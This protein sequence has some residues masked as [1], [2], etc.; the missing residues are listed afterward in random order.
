MD[1]QSTISFNSRK[2]SDHEVPHFTPCQIV[3]SSQDN[4]LLRSR[5][6][7]LI[8]QG[9]KDDLQQDVGEIILPAQ[10]DPEEILINEFDN[11]SKR[12]TR[13][14]E[15]E[16]SIT[17]EDESD[18][19]G[20]RQDSGM[21][22]VMAICSCL[23]IFSTWG[24]N[25]AYGVFLNYYIA[26]DTFPNASQYDYALIGGLV[27]F[28]AQFL[29][30]L[31][32]LA[33]N[34]VGFRILMAIGVVLQTLGYILASYS[35]KLWQLYC[36]QG[37]LVGLSFV[38]IFIPATLILPTWFK[39]YLATS[40]GITV[41]GAGLGGLVFSL[42]VNAVI[43]RTGDQRWALRMVGIVTLVT[44]LIPA[45]IMKPRTAK[46]PLKTTMTKKFIGENFKLVFNFK[47]FK[48]Y[49]LVLVAMWFAFALLSYIIMLFSMAAYA[50]LVGLTS[51]QG[52]N[53][54][55]IMNAAQIVGRPAMGFGADYIGRSTCSSLICA[56]IT[57]LL[58]AFWINAKTYAS[59][60]VFVILIG[61]II[62]VGS[63]MAQAMA[64]EVVFTPGDLPAAWAGMNIFVGIATLVAEVIALSLVVET[65]SNPYL[66]AQ[67]FAGC[68]FAFCFI[69]ALI[70]REYLVRK[71]LKQRLHVAN[72]AI[73]QYSD[74][75]KISDDCNLLQQRIDRYNRL[76][77]ND[78]LSFFIRVFYPVRV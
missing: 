70:V 48:S 64:A 51:Q 10:G 78:P 22:W 31:A 59:L 50:K 13:N 49:P 47:V 73:E 66:H 44:A 67:I 39:K 15:E 35:T 9:I 61:L 33:Y 76:L 74:E 7:A 2:S 63:T 34:I 24:S 52:S 43:E 46:L 16:K 26:N 29:A 60:I 14:T 57:I 27:M 54:T 58:L 21:A 41:A 8:L 30:P 38:C 1:Q 53:L 71:K 5:S 25:A 12:N 37:L 19:D 6:N 4:G 72:I 28:C 75:S 77:A 56:I 42:S 55:S 11:I 45:V 68:I 69:L 17:A 3:R 32:A 40:M 20:P 36:T 18:T 23:A 62:G 65:S